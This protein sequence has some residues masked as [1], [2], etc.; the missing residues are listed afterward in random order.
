VTKVDTGSEK[1]IIDIIKKRFPDHS[2]LAEESKHD[3]E[4]DGYRWIIDPLDG[5]T[6]FIHGFSGHRCLNRAAV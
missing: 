1:I 4:T 2:I 6:N 3:K 5:T